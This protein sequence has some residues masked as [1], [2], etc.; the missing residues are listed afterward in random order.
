MQ[1]SPYQNVLA[2]GSFDSTVKLWDLLS[3]SHRAIQTLSDFRDSV[4]CLRVTETQII[5]SSVDGLLRVYD[6]RRGKRLDVTI[7]VAINSFDLGIDPN[8]VACSCLDSVVR[9]IDISDGSM[10][11]EYKGGH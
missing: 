7:G 3:K 5:A 2:T 6:M 9:M 4:T 10:V 8:F 11:A 1:L